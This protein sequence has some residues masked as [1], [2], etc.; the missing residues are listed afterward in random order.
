MNF[1]RLTVLWPQGTILPVR[2][3][4]DAKGSDLIQLLHFSVSEGWEMFL[5]YKGILLN[6]N[7]TLEDQI[8]DEN[9][10]LY[11]EFVPQGSTVSEIVQSTRLQQKV[12][13][14]Y[15]ESLRL[16]DLKYDLLESHPNGKLAYE[17]LLR[18]EQESDDPEE[19]EP[20]KILKPD[21]ISTSPLPAFWESNDDLTDVDESSD[22]S[23]YL[24]PAEGS[25]TLLTKR[26]KSGWTW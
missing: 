12:Q 5:I 13:E 8:I 1:L 22:K 4:K 17:E 26:K 21:K 16:N 6:P 14:L 9:A 24:S 25:P 19:D 11:V 10:T 18:L 23:N 20:T 7:E 15:I 2:V 3:R